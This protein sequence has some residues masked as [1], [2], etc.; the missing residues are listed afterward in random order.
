MLS[1]AIESAQKKLEGRNF[2]I[3][4]NVLEYDDV[5]NQQ[6]EIIY[7][8]AARCWTA[9]ISAPRCTRCCARTSI[10]AA[11]SSCALRRHYQ[12]WLTT[13]D[14]FRYTVADFDNISREGI[15]DLLYNR[16]MRSCGQ[17]AATARP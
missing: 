7:G 13:D 4:K 6:R 11:A 1:N 10:P 14:D 17:G 8:S 2:Q 12:G 5:M 3:R 9:R 15:V 16:G